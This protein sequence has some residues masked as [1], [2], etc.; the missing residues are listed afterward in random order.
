[1]TVSLYDL[2]VSSYLQIYEGMIGSLDKGL[3]YCRENGINPNEISGTR[4]F[5]DMNSFDFQVQAVTHHS[6]GAL[7]ALK[8]GTYV[9]QPEVPEIGYEGL[10][11][12]LLEARE[13]LRRM[14]PEEINGYQGGEVVF[15]YGDISIPFTAE[16]FVLSFSL[17]NFYFH[18]ATAYD[19]LRL[20]G[21]PVGKID[22]LGQLRIKG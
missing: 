17:P 8:S 2:G 5:P 12:L 9:P 1:M 16:N 22:F 3:A 19:I 13:A 4:L 18:A 6:I 11:K 21:V 15:R 7:G 14:S 10:Q 20:K